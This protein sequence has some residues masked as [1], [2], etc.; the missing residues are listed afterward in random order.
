MIFRIDDVSVNTNLDHLG[1]LLDVVRRRGPI[2]GSLTIMLAVSP[3]VFDVS[4]D[5]G[6]ETQRAFPRIISAYSDHRLF[7]CVQKLGVPDLSRLRP[8]TLAS[9]GLIHVDHR[10]LS[11]EAQ[12]LSILTSCRVLGAQY[13][14]PP[15]NHW[16]EHTEVVCGRWQIKLV[17]FEE[18]WRHTSFQ[19]L[20][21]RTY[22]RYYCH[23][24]DT[25]PEQLEQWFHR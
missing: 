8:F 2:D 10:L 6:L 24:H 13:F 7:Y 1:R 25:T 12:E 23:T 5:T 9:H 3:L 21:L 4:N 20:D 17:K 11:P 15:F 19:K 14:V 22:D 16:N 18:G